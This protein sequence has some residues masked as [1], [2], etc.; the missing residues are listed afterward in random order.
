[1]IKGYPPF[2]SGIQL[3]VRSIFI[4]RIVQGLVW[5]A[6]VVI[7][8][9]LIFFP[10]TGINMFWNI[11]I[12]V[13]PF[14][15]VV[16]T[17]VWRNICPM[18]TNA[19][20]PR[21]LDISKRKRL[22]TTQIA[23]LNLLAVIALYVIIPLRHAFF[24]TNG[25]ATAIL[26]SSMVLISFIAGFFFEWKSAWCSGLCP[27]H[28]VEK[29]YGINTLLS[30]PNAHCGECRNC[31]IPC[32]DSTP[33]IHSFSTTKTFYHKISGYLM[34]GG[35]PGFVWGWFHVPDHASIST[36]VQL[37]EIYT[38]PLL[39]ATAT[40]LLF[41]ILRNVFFKKSEST[42]TSIFAAAAVACYYWYRIPSLVGFGIY[43]NDAVLINLKNTIPAWSVFAVVIFTTV[44]FFWWIVFRKA[45]KK[46][47]VIRPAFATEREGSSSK[48]IVQKK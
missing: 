36:L 16:F 37:V 24:N 2:K 18:A 22:S 25:M 34:V 26:I 6:S 13:A 20:L 27:V 32:P 30:V 42:I 15:L 4:W 46:S 48:N 43:E 47:W 7:L 41:E 14:L 17:G 33:G 3:S 29:L 39:G 1:M 9:C 19:L 8:F 40:L 11:L 35:F 10:A 45:I 5:F 23:K 31:V 28:P 21:H 38:L 12:P 44:F